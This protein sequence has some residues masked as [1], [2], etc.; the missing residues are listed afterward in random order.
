MK[1]FYNRFFM[2]VSALMV[3]VVSLAQDAEIDGICYN[4]NKATQEA[5][6]TSKIA[7]G[8][9]DV[10]EIPSTVTHNDTVYTV[11]GIG[12]YA[13]SDCKALTS[14]TLPSSL[15]KIGTYAFSDCESLTTVV[16]PDNVTDI[17]ESA[18]YRCTGLKSIVI[19][20]LVKT[21]GT[22]AFSCCSNLSSVVIGKSV[23]MFGYGVF[24][25]C[26]SLT[27]IVIPDNVKR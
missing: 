27:S 14:V 25:W 2:L 13:F 19:P 3:S 20:D 17:E 11:T 15:K 24:S 22:S 16:I 7:D 21:V 12:D 10:V 18:F 5:S 26:T 23:T 8:Y 6:V 1:T 9:S 4:F